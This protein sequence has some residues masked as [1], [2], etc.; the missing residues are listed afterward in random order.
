[1][2]TMLDAKTDT[3][4]LLD[5]GAG[6]GSLAA[7]AIENLLARRKPPRTIELTAVEVDPVLREYLAQ[8]LEACRAACRAKRV[9]FECE[10]VAG[11]FLEAAGDWLSKDGLFKTQQARLFDCAILNPPYRKINSESDARRLLRDVGIETTNLYSAFLWLTLRLL[12]RTG[13]MVAITPRSFCNGP[14]FRQFREELLSTASLSHVHVFDSRKK[15]FGDDGV[16]Q[17]NI[18][19]RATRPATDGPT[20]ISTSQGPDD[21]DVVTRNVSRDQ[22]V[23]AESV[24]HVAADELQGQVAARIRE[25]P[26]TLPELDLEVSTGRVVD[27]RAKEF[28]TYDEGDRRVRY[29]PLIYPMHFAEGRILWP[30][31][32]KKPN[33]L[34]ITRE[35]ESL[36]VPPGVYVLVKRFSAKEEKR[37]VVAV[38][39][40]PKDLPDCPYG[41]ENH[42]N[43]FHRGGEGLPIT[44]ATG[45]AAYLN[46]SLVDAYFRQFSGHTQ[47]NASDLRSIPY[48]TLDALKR[49]GRAIG[50]S[51]PTQQEIDRHITEELPNVA[52][53]KTDPLAAKRRIEEALAILKLLGLPR[54]QQNDRS[55]LTLLALTEVKPDTAWSDASSPLMGITPIMDFSKDHYGTTYAPNTRETFRRQTMHQFVEAGMALYNPDNPK[56]PVNS[57]KAVYQI[58]PLLLDVLRTH[59]TKQ[60]EPMLKDWSSQIETLKKRYAREREMAKIPLKLPTGQQIELSPGGQNVLV[61]QIIHEFCPRFTPG[62]IPVYIGDTEEKYAHFDKRALDALGVAIDA[63]GKMPDVVIHYA[64]KNWLLLIEAVTSHGPVDGKRRDELRRL[65]AKSKAPLVFVTAFMD[66]SAMVRFLG[67]ISW[68]TE[69]WVADAPTHMIH[70]NG[71]RF[72]GPYEGGE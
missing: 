28:L 29:A 60:W 27:F 68:E 63:H 1:M 5:P 14:Y 12:S 13:E 59:G 2:A 34:R 20:L 46:S 32:G 7:A 33:R 38:V 17:E 62:G 61:E 64:D 30:R 52:K 9:G 43:Y 55:A 47:V 72:L 67:D 39:C 19:F 11:D 26:A 57:P 36:L 16:L 3:V 70:F 69:V 37:R 8:T 53:S 71:E 35:T 31:N 21:P 24:I 49:I 48:P 23:G 18:V 51:I 15:A 40:R 50:N 56:R 54:A 22:L 66:R 6:V 4:R 25:F 42:L 10:L 44:V 58:A 45:L 41:F 65:F